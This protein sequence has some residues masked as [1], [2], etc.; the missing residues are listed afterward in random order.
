[1]DFMKELKN[2]KP[3]NKSK[4]AI[5]I[6]CSGGVDSVFL[7][8]YLCNL[9]KR[10]NLIIHASYVDHKLRPESASESKIVD[11]ICQKLEIPF[12]FTSFDDNFWKNSSSNMEER[13]RKERYRLLHDLAVELNCTYVATGHHLDDQVETV[14]MRIFDRGTGIK[15][16]VGI[17]PVQDFGDIK[18]IRPLLSLS[19]KEIEDHMEGKKYITDSSNNDT[20]IRR[21]HFRKEVIPSVEKTLKNDEFKKHIYNLSLNAQ[22]EVEF[23]KVAAKEFWQQFYKSSDRCFIIS[24]EEIEKY[25]DNFW[26]TA[27]SYLFSEY[28]DFSHCTETLIDIVKFIR[29]KDPTQTNYDPFIFLRNREE[30][31]IQRS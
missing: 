20:D 21:N 31:R 22:R 2:I 16:L 19:R 13:A 7:L 26:L 5:L 6:A 14:L 24:R 28:R 10:E 9:K 17:K 18:I 29:K 27:F 11:K 1:M 8:H 25:S 4:L 3:H 23:T 15:G 30:I 12:H